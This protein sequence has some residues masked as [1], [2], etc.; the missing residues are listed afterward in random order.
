MQ[1]QAVGSRQ[2]AAGSRNKQQAPKSAVQHSPQ[3][4]I[5]GQSEYVVLPSPIDDIDSV[6]DGSHILPVQ[7]HA[8][9]ILEEILMHCCCGAPRHK[10][11]NTAGAVPVV[12]QRQ[13]HLHSRLE[14]NTGMGEGPG[15]Q[16]ISA[17]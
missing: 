6:D 5:A 11:I 12:G 10:L 7:L 17:T 16:C 13:D 8:G 1:R 14:S 2:Q 15:S 4:L 3:W 9:R